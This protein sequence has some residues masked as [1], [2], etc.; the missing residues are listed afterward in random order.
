MLNH[1][2]S[3]QLKKNLIRD[4][5]DSKNTSVALVSESLPLAPR[6]SSVVIT[7]LDNTNSE[8]LSEA[9]FDESLALLTNTFRRFARKRN[10][11]K[12]SPLAITDKPKST[13]VDKASA[14]CYN[15]QGKGH[16]ASEC[17]YK[18]NRFISST[19]ASPSSKNDKY[20][21]LKEKYRKMKSLKRGKALIV[22]DH[23]W[24]DSSDSLDDEEDIINLGL[25]AFNDEADLSLMAK[26]EEVPE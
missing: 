2:Q 26:I 14:I 20:Q 25:M 19:S 17:S 7:E 8:D 15:C 13:P 3:I 11:Q 24:A 12:K 5:K 6:T 16:F 22:E 18:K 4:A 23:D 1:E 10:F 9:D 21:K